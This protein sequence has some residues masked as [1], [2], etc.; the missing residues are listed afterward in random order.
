MFAKSEPFRTGYLKT[1]SVYSIY[2][3]VS[4]N[5]RGLPA[6]YIHGGPGGGLFPNYTRRFDPKKFMIIG[7]EQRGCGRSRPWVSEVEDL[8]TNTTP[9]LISDIETLRKELNI[10]QWVVTGGSWGTTLAL[11]YAQQHPQRVKA[12]VLSAV[13]TTSEKEVRWITE[14]VGAI[15]PEKWDHFFTAVQSFE[16]NRLIDRYY[17]ALRSTDRQIRQLAA[18]AW[19]QWEDVHVSMDPHWQ[20]MQAF[21]DPGYRLRFA[22]LVVHY[23]KHA[24]FLSDRPILSHMDKLQNI[25]AVLIH[26]RMDVSGPLTTAWELHKRWPGSQLRVVEKEGHG[27]SQMT[28]EAI[29]ALSTI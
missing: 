23:W 20:P 12:M 22:T 14:D 1:D 8:S 27:G 9:F 15:F 28:A 13:T 29:Q 6:L 5:P 17:T 19:C 11:A 2:W 10:D 21:E 16:G 7:F 3:E 4:G 18:D 26:G 25:P 24:G